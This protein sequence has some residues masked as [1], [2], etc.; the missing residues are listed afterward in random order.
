M[1][2]PKKGSR[3]LSRNDYPD[4]DRDYRF[5]VKQARISPRELKVF[6]QEDVDRPGAPLRFLAGDGETVTPAY[7]YGIIHQALAKGW[8][9]EARG[10]VFKAGHSEQYTINYRE[11]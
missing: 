9:P 6:V 4:L 3:V 5:I 10:P 7:V 1:G 2:I 8:K 11:T